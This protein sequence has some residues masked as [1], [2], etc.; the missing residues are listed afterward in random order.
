[1]NEQQLRGKASVLLILCGEPSDERIL[2]TRRAAH[3]NIHAGEIAFP[4]GKW[5]PG[6]SDL[7]QTALREVNE[8]VGLYS[9]DLAYLHSLPE[10]RTRGQIPV[11]PFVARI[12]SEPELRL[13]EDEIESAKWVPL[14]LFKDD[15]RARTHIFSSGGREIWAPVYTYEDYEIW[16]LTARVMVSFV[17][18]ILGGE[19][20]REH[21][22][23]HEE[24]YK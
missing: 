24:R 3:L 21:A 10:H 20:T 2:L 6:D 14:S 7:Y 5:E 1:M 23:A 18:Q 11:K 4:G 8:E 19:I 9:G 16:G 22:S 17:N 15:Q 12:K 13:C